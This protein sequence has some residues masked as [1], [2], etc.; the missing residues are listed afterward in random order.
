MQRMAAWLDDGITEVVKTNTMKI[1]LT[2]SLS[3]RAV[4]SN[5]GQCG[6]NDDQRVTTVKFNLDNEHDSWQWHRLF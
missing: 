2:N 4:L 5:A 3:A 1:S 6:E